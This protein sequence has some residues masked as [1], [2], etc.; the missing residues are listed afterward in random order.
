MK[1]LYK[2]TFIRQYGK[3]DTELKN[4]ILEKLELFKNKD[5]HKSLNLHKL[6]GKLKDFYSFSINYKIR[7]VFILENDDAILLAVGDH[8]LYK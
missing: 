5:S 6:N 1:I 4:E 2:P 3:L 7:V 8:S